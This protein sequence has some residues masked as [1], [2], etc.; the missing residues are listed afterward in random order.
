MKKDEAAK[1]FDASICWLLSPQYRARDKEMSSS[2][3]DVCILGTKMNENKQQI[4]HQSW[5]Y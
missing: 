4:T 5:Y 3:R 2:K 1:R